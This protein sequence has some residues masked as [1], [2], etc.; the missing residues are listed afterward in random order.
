MAFASSQR[1]IEALPI[2]DIAV[3]AGGTAAASFANTGI[4]LYA[5]AAHRLL[6]TLIGPTGDGSATMDLQWVIGS[7]D[8][9]DGTATLDATDY[10]GLS[11]VD[12]TISTLIEAV[13]ERTDSAAGTADPFVQQLEVGS[14]Y[15]DRAPSTSASRRAY[16]RARV[17]HN[18]DAA[19][20]MYLLI[21][22]MPRY[23]E[24]VADQPS[25]V[26]T[27]VATHDL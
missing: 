24:P 10:V 14:I 2:V 15:L 7:Y 18:T 19:G 16:L 20:K 23:S 6:F 27:P 11:A 26:Q 3:G 1:I 22:K 9:T 4:D 25:F 8:L 17:N 21:Q 5:L 12:G 13:V